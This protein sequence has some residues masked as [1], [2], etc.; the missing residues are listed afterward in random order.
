MFAYGWANSPAKPVRLPPKPL[1][2]ATSMEER[3]RRRL[4]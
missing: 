2:P 3:R 4:A 1:P